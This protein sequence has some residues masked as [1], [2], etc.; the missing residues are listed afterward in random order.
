VNA[1]IHARKCLADSHA[2]MRRSRYTFCMDCGA[3]L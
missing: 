2:K 1:N 3:G